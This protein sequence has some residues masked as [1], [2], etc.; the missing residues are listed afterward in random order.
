M[1]LLLETTRS[2]SDRETI[3]T[4][5]LLF[6]RKIIVFF[7]TV[8]LCSFSSSPSPD[9]FTPLKLIKDTKEFVYVHYVYWF[10]TVLEIETRTL[11]NAYLLVYLKVVMVKAL[12]AVSYDIS[13][14]GLARFILNYQYVPGY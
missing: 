4:Y 13:S 10:L 5:V 6:S 3:T 14:Y 12:Y 8:L 1:V 2:N 7:L 9:P 11:K